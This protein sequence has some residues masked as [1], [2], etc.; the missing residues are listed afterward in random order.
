MHQTGFCSMVFHKYAAV[1]KQKFIVTIGKYA[2]P[3]IPQVRTNTV[4]KQS[5][6]L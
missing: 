2:K 4:K 6:T 1:N 5:Y 3:L